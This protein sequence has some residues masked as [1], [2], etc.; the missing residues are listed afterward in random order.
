MAIMTAAG[1]DVETLVPPENTDR[2]AR[3][4]LVRTVSNLLAVLTFPSNQ[5]VEFPISQC[6]YVD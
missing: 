4:H 2:L 6:Y 5:N 1:S 3:Q